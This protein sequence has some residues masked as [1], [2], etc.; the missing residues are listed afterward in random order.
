MNIIDNIL[1]WLII[2]LEL[3]MSIGILIIGI[4]YDLIHIIFISLF[5]FSASFGMTV[6]HCRLSKKKVNQK[7][8]NT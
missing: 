5:G 2:L 6:V 4:N 1:G 7:R 8:S 3:S